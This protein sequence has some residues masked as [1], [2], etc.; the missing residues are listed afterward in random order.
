MKIN[1]LKLDLLQAKRE[2]NC[3]QLAEK[4]G[5]SRQNLSTIRQR[6][7]CSILSAAKIAKALEVELTEII[8]TEE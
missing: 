7:T 8:E 1:K 6:G 2:M 4:S 3:T 5:I